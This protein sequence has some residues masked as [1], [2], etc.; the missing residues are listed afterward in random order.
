MIYRAV[1]QGMDHRKSKV[2][3]KPQNSNAMSFRRLR[4]SAVED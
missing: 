3:V 1:L 2:V 4:V